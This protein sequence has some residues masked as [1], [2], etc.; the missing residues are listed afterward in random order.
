MAI[1]SGFQPDDDGSIPFTRSK[2]R[3]RF[4]A[5]LAC[6]AA[7]SYNLHMYFVYILQS[8]SDGKTYVGS[9]DNVER[10]LK[11][12][13]TGRSKATKHRGPLKLLFTEEFETHLEAARREKWWKSST[14]RRKLKEYFEKS[15]L[16]KLR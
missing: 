13:N 11:E 15:V 16:N 10:R 7:R 6:R 5:R 1:T 14:G 9:T 4:G 3:T 2:S 8:S 12:H